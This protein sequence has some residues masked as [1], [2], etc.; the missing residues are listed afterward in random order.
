M[1]QACV[2]CGKQSDSITGV[3]LYWNLEGQ[4]FCCVDCV[5]EAT[6]AAGTTELAKEE[7]LEKE[8]VSDDR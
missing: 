6:T 3:T 1:P 4:N 2:V 8:K 5:S 7:N